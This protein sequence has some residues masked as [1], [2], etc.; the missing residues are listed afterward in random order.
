MFRDSVY[1]F[2]NQI[3]PRCNKQEG[4]LKQQLGIHAKTTQ[5]FTEG[6]N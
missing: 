6:C 1:A 3:P 2:K 5:K 4:I